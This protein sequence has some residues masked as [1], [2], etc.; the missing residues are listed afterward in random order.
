MSCMDVMVEQTCV[1]VFG[2][3]EQVCCVTSESAAVWT[4]D[5]S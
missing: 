1:A 5:I 2:T 3:S 4:V